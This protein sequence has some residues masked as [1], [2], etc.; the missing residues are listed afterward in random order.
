VELWIN[1]VHNYSGK[2]LYTCE[3]I[4]WQGLRKKLLRVGGIYTDSHIMIFSNRHM[5][6]EPPSAQPKSNR[7]GHMISDTSSTHE[8]MEIIQRRDTECSTDSFKQENLVLLF[9]KPQ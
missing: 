5:I 4:N 9:F 6:C 8:R 2:A 3:V 7:E 1:G